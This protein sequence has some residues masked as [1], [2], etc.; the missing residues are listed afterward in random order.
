MSRNFQYQGTLEETSL[1][2]MLW[3]IYRHK[4]PGV[5]EIANDGIVKRILVSGGSVIH[6]TS[7][8]RT[9]RLGAFLYR[10]GQLSRN[11]L[12]ET[13]KEREETGKRHGQLL[14]ERGLLA[15]DE[16]YVA[17]RSQIESIVWGLFSWQTGELSFSI[18]EHED[19][20]MINIHL[21]MRQVIVQ[22]IKK[23]QDA[24]ALVGRLGKKSSVFRPSY[25]AED[26]IEI[27]L[28]KEEYELLRLVDGERSLYDVC[29]SGPYKVSENARLLYAYRVLHLIELIGT[30]DEIAQADT[31]T[32][33]D[34]QAPLSLS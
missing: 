12:A 26:L 17:I 1:A 6:A 9:D 25:C 5:I 19:P 10:K 3:T 33:T 24:K 4:V 7:T 27:A 8:D 13:M 11:D 28:G 21:P 32:V 2:E 15:P 31:A 16:L 34:S 22:G 29:N 30:D 18:G 20:F 14:I 23:A